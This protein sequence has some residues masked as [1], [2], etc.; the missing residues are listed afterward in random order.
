MECGESVSQKEGKYLE[1]STNAIPSAEVT[2]HITREEGDTLPVHTGT[3]TASN[4]TGVALD[5]SLSL[6]SFP[7]PQNSEDAQSLSSVQLTDATEPV[8]SRAIFVSAAEI[9]R[10]LNENDIERQAK[11]T[12]EVRFHYFCPFH[13]FLLGTRTRTA[14]FSRFSN[15]VLKD[16]FI[17]SW[18]LCSPV[19]CC[20][21]IQRTRARAY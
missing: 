20:S 7:L 3:C 2:V 4:A 5:D 14:Q 21:A 12:F 9:R 8:D 16:R 13:C 15:T 1:Q 10:R 19:L 11:R 17:Y 6:Q 18:P